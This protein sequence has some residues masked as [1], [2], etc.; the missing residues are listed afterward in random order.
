MLRNNCVLLL[1]W[2]LGQLDQETQATVY[3]HVLLWITAFSHLG[4]QVS[5]VYQP[6]NTVKTR[7]KLFYHEG[8]KINRTVK[9]SKSFKS[10][11]S[12]SAYH[13]DFQISPIGFAE[14][15]L[16]WKL[17]FPVV[18]LRGVPTDL[19]KMIKYF[20]LILGSSTSLLK[21]RNYF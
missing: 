11:F 12:K 4:Q 15:E 18:Y 14:T 3:F 20:K 13:N 9:P 8:L 21:L 17:C 16:P 19:V 5:T 1:L 7:G 6:G 2:F 10:P